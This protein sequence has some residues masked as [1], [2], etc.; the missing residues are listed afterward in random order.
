M[1]ATSYKNHDMEIQE[2]GQE[3]LQH[4]HSHRNSKLKKKQ[5]SIRGNANDDD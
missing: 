1:T 2:W 4:E 3:Q 5:Q